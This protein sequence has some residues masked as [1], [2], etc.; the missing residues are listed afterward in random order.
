MRGDIKESILFLFKE[1]DITLFNKAELSRRYN[2]DPRTIERYI[3]IAKGEIEVVSQKREYKSKLDE[4][5][6]I[7]INKIDKYGCTAKAVYQLIQKKGYTGKYSILANFVKKHKDE[8]TQ[9]AT[10]RFETNL[11]LQAKFIHAIEAMLEDT[12]N[13]DRRIGEYETCDNIFSSEE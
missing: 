3:K 8:E 5:K 11:G 13:A 2:C 4:F 10:I 7:I 1:E 12:K 9:K 6:P